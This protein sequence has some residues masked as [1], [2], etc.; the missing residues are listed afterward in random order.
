VDAFNCMYA[1]T[2]GNPDVW[3]SINNGTSFVKLPTPPVLPTGGGDEDIITLPSATRP[4]PVYLGDLAIATVSV[5]KS[6]DGGQSFF[7]P[8]TGGS[9]GELNASSDR[10]W[11]S[12]DVNGANVTLY[13]MD[14]E[15]VSE[16]IRFAAS[17]NDNP[18]VTTTGITDPELQG[19]TLPN[20]NPGP[21]FVNHT[22]HTVYGVFTSS[23]PTTNAMQPP[24]GK[25][26]NVWVAF[27]AGTTAPGTPP[28]PFTDR[29]IFKG[30]IDSPT[31]PP[32]PAGSGTFGTTTANDFPAGDIDA[33]GNVYA[34]WAM[35]NSR[36]NQYAV[37]LAASH[38]GGNTFYGPFQISAGAGS[39]EMPWVAA[40]DAGRV[41]VIFYYSPDAGDPN[42]ANLHANR[43]L[44][45][46]R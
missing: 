37:W 44:P 28:G 18:W 13:E 36:T 34:A 43:S 30:V 11:F 25:Q 29:P 21:I 19:S 42:T 4:A 33:A 2:P 1:S 16:A 7:S 10:Q 3:K 5:R 8:G 17:V 6:T 41:E 23:I 24:F 40:G 27:G 45:F 31:A 39:A 26:P 38:D 22:T 32:P 9:A 12:P 35:N 46:H 14:H 15:F 20:T